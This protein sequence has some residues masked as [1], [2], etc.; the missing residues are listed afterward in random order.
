M[1]IIEIKALSNG[2]HRNQEGDFLAIPDGYAVIPEGIKLTNFPF[3]EVV[4]EVI[5][6]VM[7]VTDWKPGIIPEPE[8]RPVS[9]SEQLRA[10]IDYIAA[11]MGVEL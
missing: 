7:T 3:G 9:A 10:D 8:P 11:M 6:G 4:V 1:K 2:A 5:N